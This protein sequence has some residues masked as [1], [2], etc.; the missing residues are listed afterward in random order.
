VLC[1]GGLDAS[2]RAGLAADAWAVQ[3]AGGSGVLV[4][5]A[6]TAQGG[7][8]FALNPVAPRVLRAQLDAAVAAGPVNAVKL[9]MV[10]NRRQLREIVAALKKLRAP[11]VVDPV[12]HTSRGERLST[13][14]PADYLGLARAQVWVTPNG[15]ELEWL[16]HPPSALVARGFGAVLVKGGD[17]AVDLLVMQ[18]FQRSFRSRSVRRDPTEHRGTGCRLASAIATRLAS[19]D[20]PETAVLRS[21]RIVLQFL[22]APIMRPAST[23]RSPFA[24]GS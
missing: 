2:G 4:A 5:T 20:S 24:P 21:R 19:R 15:A 13:L 7:R 9:G 11:W 12:T 17:R 16:R 6:L 1:I 22:L 18:S 3:R 8:R 14:G 10:A 23:G